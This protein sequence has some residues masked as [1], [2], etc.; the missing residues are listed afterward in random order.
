MTYITQYLRKDGF[1]AQ[2][3]TILN[4]ILYCKKNNKTFIY[5]PI[6]N[7]EHN[8]DNDVLF[9]QKIEK[10][11]NIKIYKSIYED[12]KKNVKI[13]HIGESINFFDKNIKNLDTEINE[14]KKDFWQNKDRNCF[15]N[16][17]FNIAVHIRRPNPDD[18]RIMGVD[19]PD[20][21]YLDKI[22][23][24]RQKY[25]DKKIMFHIYSQGELSN[26]SKYIAN[27][28]ILKI[29]MNIFDTFTEMVG[30]DA[31]IMSRSSF[32]YSAAV[33]S[34]GDIYYQKLWHPPMKHWYI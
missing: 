14:I 13:F 25:K 6:K 12:D 23:N 30:A 28:T 16:D 24:L 2:Y 27:D 3:Q 29:N 11:M 33:L 20:K 18:N 9:L 8:Y 5:T 1:G 34:D 26:F 7:I 22:N 21:Y 10:L 4:T 19:T 32:S 17:C 31:L 15:K